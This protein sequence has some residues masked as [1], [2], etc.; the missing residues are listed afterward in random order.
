M[1][2]RPVIGSRRVHAVLFLSSILLN[3]TCVRAQQRQLDQQYGEAQR[4]L[5]EGNYKKAEQAFEE[6]ANADPSVAEIH[7]NLGLIYF[8][9]KKFEQAVPALQRALKLNPSLAKSANILA[10]SLSELARYAEALPGLEKGFHSSDPEMRRMCGLQLERA[11]TGL[12]RDSDAVK[13]ALQMEQMYP[14]DP[15]VQYH[16]GKIFGNFA[17]LTMQKLWQASPDS[18]WKH[19]AEA[20]ALES[21]GSYEAA[22]GQYRDVLTRDPKRPGI[23]YRIG[24]TL[25]ARSQKTGSAQDVQDAA[26]EFGEELEL[27][28]NANAAYELGEIRRN[29]GQLEDAQKYFELALKDHPDFEEAQLGLAA[30]LIAKQKP[31]LALPHLQ[32]AIS[33]NRE[34]EVSWWR[35]AQVERSLGNSDEQKKALAEFQR[36]HAQSSGQEQS[37][38]K[39]FSS[40]EVT[41]QQIE[42]NSQN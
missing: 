40:D 24:R 33:L 14:N 3:L 25:L 31:E 35:L 19:Q 9:E 15:E 8:E 39:L 20:E 23:H 36:L 22:I 38:K 18:V 27:G 7:A 28:P 42:A 34:N 41:K 11:Y 1:I 21:Q 29:A 5:A 10:M 30:T 13:V 4:A 12:K 16:D 32:K 2:F 37:A 6:L 17:F 26:Q